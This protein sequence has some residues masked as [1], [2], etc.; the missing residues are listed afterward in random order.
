MNPQK[1]FRQ[2]LEHLVNGTNFAA[3]LHRIPHTRLYVEVVT[4]C[5]IR[6]SYSVGYEKFYLLG[7]NVV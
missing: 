6:G 1:C 7:Y 4:F 3:T 5:R 2:S